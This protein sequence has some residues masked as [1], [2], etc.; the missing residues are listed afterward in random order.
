MSMPMQHTGEHSADNRGRHPSA[1]YRAGSA[2]GPVGP[3]FAATNDRWT[4]GSV[5][6]LFGG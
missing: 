2:R 5:C 1:A 3:E 4:D 6:V